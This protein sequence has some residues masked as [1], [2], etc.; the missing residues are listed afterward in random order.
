MVRAHN[1]CA[2]IL[3]FIEFTFMTSDNNMKYASY[4]LKNLF[5]KTECERNK[6]I[7]NEAIRI[8][9]F[10]LESQYIENKLKDRINSYLN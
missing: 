3:T 8:C 2:T 9:K 4:L 1:R 7:R 6:S 5:L 10:F